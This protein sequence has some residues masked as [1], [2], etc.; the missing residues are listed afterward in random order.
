MTDVEKWMI[1]KELS[2]FKSF[3]D[4]HKFAYKHNIMFEEHEWR[5]LRDKLLKILNLTH[6]TGETTI[7]PDL[8]GFVMPQ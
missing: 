7:K 4:F 2:N 6:E 5:D 1:E 8:S 3:S